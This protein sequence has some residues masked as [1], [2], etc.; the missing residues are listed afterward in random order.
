MDTL[1]QK[2][3]KHFRIAAFK[4]PAADEVFE[5]VL[6][7]VRDH[8]SDAHIE[9]PMKGIMYKLTQ[10]EKGGNVVGDVWEA[11]RIINLHTGPCI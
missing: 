3:E 10:V 8:A 9:L 4:A 11:Q 5:S 6:Q 7:H 1:V 2:L